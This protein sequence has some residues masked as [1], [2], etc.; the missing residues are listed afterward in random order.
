MTTYGIYDAAGGDREPVV[1][2]SYTDLAGRTL[3]AT[4]LPHEREQDCAYVVVRRN[5]G[6]GPRHL[7]EASRLHAGELGSCDVVVRGHGDRA[8]LVCL[9]CSVRTQPG[10]LLIE[11]VTA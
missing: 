6:V 4:L 8:E 5:A 11:D 9:S 10:S 1:V 3:P 7:V 2:E